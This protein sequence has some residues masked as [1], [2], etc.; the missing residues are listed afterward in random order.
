MNSDPLAVELAMK[1]A[2]LEE[3]LA[4]GEIPKADRQLSYW[5][6]IREM[7]DDVRS[8]AASR[9]DAQFAGGIK[10]R[11]YRLNDHQVRIDILE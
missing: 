6:R 10:V 8:H 5:E 2:L 9:L 4:S 3:K 11:V 7:T 1:E